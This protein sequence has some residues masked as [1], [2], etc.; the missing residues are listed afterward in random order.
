MI[1]ACTHMLER[2]GVSRDHISYDEF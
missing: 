2:H 1:K